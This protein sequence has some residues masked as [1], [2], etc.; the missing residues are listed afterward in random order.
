M[1]LYELPGSLHPFLW[2]NSTIL[3]PWDSPCD[4]RWVRL[5]AYI[6]FQL[7]LCQLKKLLPTVAYYQCHR[8][9]SYEAS[10]T[11]IVYIS[12]KNW[13]TAPMW[14]EKEI[15]ATLSLLNWRQLENIHGRVQVGQGS[16][17]LAPGRKQLCSHLPQQPQVLQVLQVQLELFSFTTCGMAAGC[18][19]IF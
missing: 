3:T 1:M 8:P 2:P 13:A 12:I 16:N 7:Q 19:F 6:L 14:C 17:I 18:Y 11:E 9:A 10:F 5:S 4:F 15:L